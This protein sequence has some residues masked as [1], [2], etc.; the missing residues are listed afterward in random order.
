MRRAQTDFETIR[1]NNDYYGCRLRYIPRSVR[2]N[3][4]I[5]YVHHATILKFI[6]LGTDIRSEI[7]ARILLLTTKFSRKLLFRKSASTRD[8]MKY[9]II[10]KNTTRRII[11]SI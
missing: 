2:G 1:T 8:E 6:V 9:D 10:I 3:N 4:N 5:M 7:V 11:T